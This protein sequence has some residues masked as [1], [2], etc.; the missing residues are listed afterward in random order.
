MLAILGL[1]T[2]N[3]ASDNGCERPGPAGSTPTVQYAYGTEQW[4]RKGDDGPFEE[5]YGAVGA[6]LLKSPAEA[7]LDA[8]ELRTLCSP[9]EIFPD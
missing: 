1:K 7:A 9:R 3:V 2:Q 6:T 4:F 8:L 5:H